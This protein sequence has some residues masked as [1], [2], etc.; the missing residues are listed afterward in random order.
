M[1]IR[2]DALDVICGRGRRWKSHRG[3]QLF[4]KLVKEKS[5]EYAQATAKMKRDVVV[6]II[7]SS[8]GR[9]LSERGGLLVQLAPQVVSQK[10][11]QALRDAW[12]CADSKELS[13]EPTNVSTFETLAA[14]VATDGTNDSDCFSTRP[15]DIDL[16]LEVGRLLAT[17]ESDP[18]L[19]DFSMGSVDSIECGNFGRSSCIF[20]IPT[21]TD[22]LC[23][24]GKQFERSPGNIAFRR[25]ILCN[26]I[27]YQE[28]DREQKHL[29]LKRIY[30]RFLSEG[31]RFLRRN[32]RNTGWQELELP[33]SLKRIGQALRDCFRKERKSS[34]RHRKGVRAAK[35]GRTNATTHPF[36]VFPVDSV[37]TESSDFAEDAASWWVCEAISY[38]SADQQNL[39]MLLDIRADDDTSNF[40]ESSP[41]SQNDDLANYAG[42]IPSF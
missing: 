21:A 17:P 30:S 6:A 24:R 22:I 32:H 14:M 26:R 7:Q 39:E 2:L 8:T 29:M 36:N 10:I 12:T 37:K 18:L 27:V 38:P 9:F 33:A 4:S 23:C 28:Q 35:Q 3:N 34:N 15:T 41:W 19:D 13:H 5:V 20:L 40:L 31:R 25:I 11:R 1:T 16:F 42:P